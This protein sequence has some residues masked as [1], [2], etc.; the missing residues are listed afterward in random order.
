MEK[1]KASFEVVPVEAAWIEVWKKIPELHQHVYISMVLF[2][3]NPYAPCAIYS[4][5]T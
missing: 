1:T 4:D 5:K 3:F 2:S